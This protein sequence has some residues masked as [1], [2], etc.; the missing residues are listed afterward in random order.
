MKKALAVITGVAIIASMAQARL[1][2]NIETCNKRYGDPSKMKLDESQTGVASYA[3]ND[4]T[5]TVHLTGGKVDLIRYSPG[6]VARV[7][8]ETAE[9]LLEINGRDKKW[10]RLTD[11]EETVY[12]DQDERSQKPRIRKVDPVLWT[13]KDGLLEASYSPS[14][15]TL[16]I[17][18]SAMQLRVREGL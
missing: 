18:A 8:Y 11:V 17:K 15:G 2:E 14:R 5:I 13:T 7:D 6:E 3:K 4:L 16:E 9:F 12:A 1:G 10:D